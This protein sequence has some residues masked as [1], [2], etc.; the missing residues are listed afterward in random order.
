[1]TAQEYN[2][3]GFAV[4]L[5]I[6]QSIIDRAEKDIREAYI[7][8]IVG[9]QAS[10]VE[11]EDAIANLV[12]FLMTQRNI[13]VTRSGAKDKMVANSRSVEMWDTLQE[14]AHTC[15]MK[16]EALKQLPNANKDAVVSDICRL[17]FKTN[18]FYS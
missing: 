9:S 1:M 11:V 2:A 12:F 7:N 18:F 5:H 16:L 6:D 3:K 8:P 15:A 14:Q 13:F 10:G 17:Y 4:S